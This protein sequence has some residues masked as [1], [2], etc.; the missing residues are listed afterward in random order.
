MI[1]L[2]FCLAIFFLASMS[3]GSA[4]ELPGNKRARDH[5][6]KAQKAL[7]ARQLPLAR[8]LFEKVLEQEPTHYD[9]HLRLAQIAEL[10]RNG[11]QTERYYR[12]MVRLQP[13][14]PQSGPALHW[15]GR[16]KF[17][18]EAYDSAQYFFEKS[19]IL[20]PEKSNLLLVTDLYIQSCT[21]ARQAL[22]HP[23]AID[24]VSLGDTVNFLE[25]QYF[26]VLTG[27]S[28]TLLF[29][30]QTRERDENIYLSNRI[31]GRWQ[32]PQPI[33]EAIN[34]AQNEGT[35]SISADGRTLVFT[36]CNRP[37]GYG[38]CDLYISH[39]KG[40]AWS[41]PVNLGDIINSRSWESQPSLS[42]DGRTLYFSSDRK[43]GQGKKDIWY[44]ARDESGSWTAP[45]NAGS[46]IN[47][48]MDDVAPFIHANGRSLFFSSD[49]YPGM[50]G[51][52]L[53]QSTLTDS[54]WSQPLNLGYPINTIGDQVGFFLSSDGLQAY[55]TDDVADPG[56]S[57]LYTFAL[58]ANLRNKI[59][60]TRYVKGKLLNK[61]TQGP[62]AADITLF[63]LSRQTKVGE[64]HSDTQNGQFLAVLNRDS[65]Y[66]MHIEKP[67]FLFKSLTFTVQDSVSVINLEI[68]LE[69]VEKDKKEVL[70]NIFF[71]S[72]SVELGQRSRIELR[73]LTQFLTDNPKLQIEISGHTDNT[74]NDATN[75]AL[76]LE[77]AKAVVEYLKQSG[78]APQRLFTKGYGSSKPIAANDTEENRQKNR[79]IEWRIL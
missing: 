3:G 50:G 34:S 68:P 51:F 75:K 23:L 48:I 70:N 46:S 28:E 78:I 57:K 32:L 35:C 19:K 24:K 63:D 18:K 20:L 79:R 38:S 17:Q 74:G 29:T 26:P 59:T 52:D 67:G 66:A 77:R 49:G 45:R 60:P 40:A 6:Q 61:S 64:Y 56:K 65:E 10:Q 11:V 22:A 1:R 44:T 42:A 30:G 27:D 71:N 12:A 5:Y 69:P 7:Q 37:D 2:V 16:N 8:E 13:D 43:E 73:R 15:L 47:T 39:K 4:Q 62:I 36:A 54:L 14:N 72:G 25:T 76:S 41:T 31:N 58:P 33:S 55:Y 21:F 53:Y 9:S